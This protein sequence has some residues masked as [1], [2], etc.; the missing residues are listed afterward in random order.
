MTAEVMPVRIGPCPV[1]CLD[2]T[3]LISCPGFLSGLCID[4]PRCTR[5]GAEQLLMLVG[6]G[7]AVPSGDGGDAA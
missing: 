7:S 1:C 6:S 4:C 2:R 5:S 3:V